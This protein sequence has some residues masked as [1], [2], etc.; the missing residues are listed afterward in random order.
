MKLIEDERN[1]LKQLSD[2]GYQPGWH[3]LVMAPR[4]SISYDPA[5]GPPPYQY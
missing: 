4:T 5:L 2:D 3:K 1:L